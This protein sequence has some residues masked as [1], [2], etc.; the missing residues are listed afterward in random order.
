MLM[1]MRTEVIASI[2][3]A[4]TS[5]PASMPR[6]PISSARAM[7]IRLAAFLLPQTRTSQSMGVSGCSSSLAE[8]F[9]KAA[10]TVTPSPRMAYACSE[11]E[12]SG[13]M[14][15]RATLGGFIAT[16]TL[17][18]TLDCNGSRSVSSRAF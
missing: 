14:K 16:F 9:W 2:A 15:T 8:T 3:L 12:P 4:L 7:A 17:T 10:T 6:V 5:A 18:R 13:G 11:A 1:P